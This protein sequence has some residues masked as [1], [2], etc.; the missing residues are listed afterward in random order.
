MTSIIIR[1]SLPFA[2]VEAAREKLEHAHSAATRSAYRSDLRCFEAWCRDHGASAL[3]ATAETVAVYLSDM[4]ATLAVASLRRRLASISAA[5]ARS[6]LPWHSGAPVIRDMLRAICR[7]TER[8]PVRAG[9]LMRD[10]VA[11]MAASCDTSTL[12][13]LRDRAL[14]LVGFAGG[15]RRS[16]LVGIEREHVSIRVDTMRVY[17]P[18]SKGDRA[19]EGAETVIARGSNLCPVAALEAWC[20]AAGITSGPVFRSVNRHGQVADDGMSMQGVCNVIQRACAAAGLDAP[21]GE[22]LSAHGLRAGCVTESY[23]RGVSDERIMA[24]VRIKSQ[25]TMRGYVRRS[26]LETESPSAALG[27]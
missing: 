24:H 12:A 7:Q 4:S 6:D 25:P 22:R 16:E 23:V 21:M 9:A 19:G 8:R 11:L 15:F 27:L 2:V 17:L 5:H 1:S 13:G 20:Q 3:P 14:L 18:R 10:H 26:R